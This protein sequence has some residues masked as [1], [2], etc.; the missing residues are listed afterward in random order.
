M[1]GRLLGLWPTVLSCP[2]PCP[3]FFQASVDKEQVHVPEL[4]HN[5][6]A[7]F[8][9]IRK[10]SDNFFLKKH[11]TRALTN[12]NGWKNAYV[13]LLFHIVRLCTVHL[14]WMSRSA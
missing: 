1:N 3:E 11:G 5:L 4:R 9:L 12:F 7:V 6:P 13:L 14:H 10:C 2:G 8:F